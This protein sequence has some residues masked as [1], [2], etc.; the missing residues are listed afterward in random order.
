MS[1]LIETEEID[2]LEGLE[3]IRDEWD[4]LLDVCPGV[5]PFQFPEWIIPWWKCFGQGRLMTLTLK[6]A[7]R[8]CGL[9]P[10]YLKNGEVAFIGG[11]ISDY[12][13]L[14]IEPS[15]ELLGTAAV[16]NHLASRGGW[17]SCRFEE[18]RPSS[19]LLA[20]RPPDG[21]RAECLPGEVCLEVRLPKTVDAFREVHGRLGNAGS[22]KQRRRLFARSLKVESATEKEEVNSTLDAL[23]MLHAKKWE[24]V[25]EGGVLQGPEIRTFHEKAAEGFWKKGVLRLYR[26]ILA[27]RTIATLYGFVNKGTFYAYLTGYDPEFSAISPG[28]LILLSAAEECIER[29]LAG[30]D[31]LRGTE[32]YKYTWKPVETRNS[33][34]II[35][36]EQR[37]QKRI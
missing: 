8:L 21:L 35:T 26:L 3:A 14:I 13:G 30:F 36:N 15:I 19:T 27:G 32:K 33:T 34:L 5:T 28:K 17:S 37:Y 2:S 20:M 11:S 22:K 12:L 10:L 24:A 16:F 9:A 23:F 6:V 7:G 18:L 29:G 31:F 4:R 25:G 1:I